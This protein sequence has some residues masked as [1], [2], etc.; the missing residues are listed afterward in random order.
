[1]GRPPIMAGKVI[2][3]DPNMKYAGRVMIVDS[4]GAPAGVSAG[5]GGG[6]SGSAATATTANVAASITVVT[7]LAAN[8]SRKGA[9][10]FN[11]STSVVYVKLG[12]AASATSFT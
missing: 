7:L 2:P 6:P 4:T 3:V 8:T 1:M 5:P 12:S 11:D 9:Y 10:I